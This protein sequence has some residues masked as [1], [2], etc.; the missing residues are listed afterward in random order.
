M[1]FV[2]LI[3]ALICAN[4]FCFS[5]TSSLQKGDYIIYSV[6]EGKIVEPSAIIEDMKNYN[7][8]FYGEQHTDII[9]HKVQFLLLQMLYE[10][11]GEK[12][13]LSM[14]MFEREVQ[15][16]VD[17]YL[18]GFIKEGYFMKDARC[19][20][21]YK[22]YRPM[23]EFVKMKK[24]NLVAAN[25]PFRYVT[26]VNKYGL[27]TLMLL[28][29]QAKKAIAPLPYNL[30]SGDYA[31]KLRELGKDEKEKKRKKKEDADSTK[32]KKL[33]VIPG[34]SLW[35]CT[36]AYSVFQYYKEHAG[37][38]ILH[39][40]GS[41]HTEEFYGIIQRL[42]EY[43]PNIRALVITSIAYGKKLTKIDFEKD[44]NMGDYLIYT[45]SKPE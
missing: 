35:D 43:D 10:K 22:D 33:D 44:K 32:T 5:Q 4:H 45:R 7:V 23:V 24:L 40:N 19:W 29:D 39:L 17:E 20:D 9:T 25:A 16:V 28:S 6:K 27:D 15:Y 34:H 18:R 14:E 42:K 31:K 41:F 21:N 38:K 13:A 11:F 26:L 8:A 36:M 3:F 37:S 30:A 2:Y 1:R 12:T